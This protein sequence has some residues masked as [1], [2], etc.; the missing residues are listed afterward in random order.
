MVTINVDFV[1]SIVGI[2]VQTFSSIVCIYWMSTNYYNPSI[3]AG[4]SVEST[5]NNAFF[6]IYIMFMLTVLSILSLA[7]E[8]GLMIKAEWFARVQSRL[9]RGLIYLLK[10]IGLLSVCGD[11]GIS[12]GTFEIAAGVLYTAHILFVLVMSTKGK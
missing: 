3:E 6:V 4:E 9:L 7:V 12:G 8:I 11:L 5:T 10:G 2:F 1:L